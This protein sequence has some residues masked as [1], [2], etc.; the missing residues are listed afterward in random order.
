[1]LEEAELRALHVHK[2][3]LLLGFVLEISGGS[4]SE[5]KRGLGFYLRGKLNRDN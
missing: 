2:R 1:M 5:H 3:I 4:P